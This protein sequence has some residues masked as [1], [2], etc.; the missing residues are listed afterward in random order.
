MTGA[1][2]IAQCCSVLW[3][4]EFK[5]S[6]LKTNF[7]LHDERLKRKKERLR[8]KAP[9]KGRCFKRRVVVLRRPRLAE[10]AILAYPVRRSLYS[11]SASTTQI[12]SALSRQKYCGGLYQTH[13]GEDEACVRRNR[14]WRNES[15]LAVLERRSS[16]S[17]FLLQKKPK[18]PF[19]ITQ[20][21]S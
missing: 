18:D 19:I 15:N 4:V 20:T 8:C 2:L 13:K 7:H 16:R 1:P 21:M 10:C 14:Y 6:S 11:R 12:V 9:V 5:L 17:F 3:S